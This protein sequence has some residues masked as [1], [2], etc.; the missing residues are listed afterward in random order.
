MDWPQMDPGYQQV[1][2]ELASHGLEALSVAA[3]RDAYHY[4]TMPGHADPHEPLSAHYQHNYNLG[5]ILNPSD[6]AS[7]PIDPNLQSSPKRQDMKSE[8]ME[9]PDGPIDPAL[10]G[11]PS[12]SAPHA[13]TDEDVALLLRHIGGLSE[14]PT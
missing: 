5:S 14:A 2:G 12:F 13:R 11:A 7:P 8:N 1:T 3:S 9:P 4:V 10:T 6:P